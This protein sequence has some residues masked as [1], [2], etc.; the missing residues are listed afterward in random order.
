[1]VS[2]C[3]MVVSMEFL[4]QPNMAD[5]NRFGSSNRIVVVIQ[6]A[7]HLKLRWINKHPQQI[8]FIFDRNSNNRP[9]VIFRNLFLWV[10]QSLGYLFFIGFQCF[11][12][13]FQQLI[14]SVTGGNLA[15]EIFRLKIKPA[16]HIILKHFDSCF[17]AVSGIDN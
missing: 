17:I 13:H 10:F 15:F 4:L 5:I 16:V 9:E 6:S 7:F 14:G 2:D 1:M 11:R 12:T 8:A 3:T